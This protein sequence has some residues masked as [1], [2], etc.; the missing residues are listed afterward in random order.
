MATHSS[1]LA[2]KIPWT[3]EPD[4][5]WGRKELDTTERLHSLTHSLVIYQITVIGNVSMILLIKLTQS[6]TL[7]CTSSSTTS[8]L[9]ISVVPRMSLLRCWL[10]SHL[11]KKPFPSLVALY[12][13][14]FPFS[15]GSQIAIGSK[16]WLMTA[17]WP[18]KNPCYMAAKCP[19]V[20]AS[21]SLLLLI[22]TALQMVLPRPS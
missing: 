16:Q 13:L 21:L 11:R 17:T 18:T 4:S 5:P 9:Q 20:S 1:T 2:W 19:E 3:E 12:N 7:Q 8:P 22:L 6:F 14:T 10:I 15:W